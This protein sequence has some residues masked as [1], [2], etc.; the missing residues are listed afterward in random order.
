MLEHSI[1]QTEKGPV[2]VVSL[3]RHTRLGDALEYALDGMRFQ[4]IEAS[5][6]TCET[7]EQQV[8]LFAASADQLGENEQLRQLAARLNSGTCSLN[9]S[10]CAMIA[11]GEQGGA[12]HIDALRLLLAANAAGAALIRQ[13]LLDAGRDLRTFADGGKHTPFAQYCAAAKELVQR[14]AASA[15]EAREK[16]RIRWISALDDGISN[17]WRMALSR[18]VAANGGVL[19][20]EAEAEETILLCEN[21]GGLPDEQTFSMLDG[22][23]EIRLLIA[24]PTGGSDLYTAAVLERACIRGNYALPPY[25]VIVFEGLSAV[26]ALMKKEETQ[27]ITNAL[28]F[29]AAANGAA[30]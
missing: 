24:S 9:G 3:G 1:A 11:D 16:R 2:T 19:T 28:Q 22:G 14:L 20:E 25:A 21:T 23:G 6:L 4:M 12:I 18:I 26:E 7:A 10:V 17:D 5:A 13:P 27:R 29:I 30:E 15:N 8:L